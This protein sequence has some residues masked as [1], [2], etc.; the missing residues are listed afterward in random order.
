[1]TL[2]DYTI[3]IEE[4]Y[5][6]ADRKTRNVRPTM[7][8]GF[9]RACKRALKDRVTNEMLQ[10]QIE[11]LTAPCRTMAQARD[12]LRELRGALAEHAQRH[13]LGIVAAG[14]HPMAQ[15]REQKL[16]GKDRYSKITGDIQITARRSM[17][18]G[19]HVHVE[20]PDP[21]RRVELMVRMIP[22]LPPLLALS[23]SSPFWQGRPTG[24][25]GYR[26]AAHD[27]MPRSGL[28]ELFATAAEYE[29]YVEAL[30]KAEIIPDASHIWWDIRPSLHHPTLELRIADV[31]T[32][33]E[34]ALCIA[35]IYRCL[36][37]HLVEHPQLN[38]GLG[39]VDRAF[40]QENKWRAQRY[41]TQASFIDRGSMAAV[42]IQAALDA[43]V[44]DLRADAEDLGC[45]AEIAHA[46]TILERG[47]SAAEQLRIFADARLTGH[48][49][50][51]ALKRVVDWL[52]QTSVENEQAPVA[53]S[54]S[55][56]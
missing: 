37:K 9:F 32:R 54:H 2:H 41:G 16:T 13:H 28:P 31:C 19:M 38:T 24:L 5:F 35:A 45:T 25:S 11:V 51:E 3:G 34:D 40:A 20:V 39:A 30:V 50:A 44:V 48:T 21:A 4:E 14:T 33:I 53:Q 22:F 52:M 1:M 27:E 18:C 55:A 36:I 12:Q 47:S 56:G 17:V 10:A 8:K 46:R 7:P 42:P 29:D 15:W 23:T 49:A 6:V 26:L 43:L